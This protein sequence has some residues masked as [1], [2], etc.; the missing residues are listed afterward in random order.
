MQFFGTLL[1]IHW[2]NTIL[3][4]RSTILDLWQ[5]SEYAYLSIST[6]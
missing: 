4:L 5:G 1:H 2:G 3:D 6:H